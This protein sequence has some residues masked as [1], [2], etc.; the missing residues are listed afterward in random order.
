MKQNELNIRDIFAELKHRLVWIILATVVFGFGAYVYS[1]VTS[2]QTY[3][4]QITLFVTNTTRTSDSHEISSAEITTSAKLVDSYIAVLKSRKVMDQV[5]DHLPANIPVSGSQILSMVK[6]SAN[7]ETEKFTVS[8]TTSNSA[9]ATA[10]ANKIGEVAPAA[11]REITRAGD[12]TVIDSAQEATPNAIDNVTPTIL[13]AVA[14]LGL[15]CL[16]IIIIFSFN[17]TIW[18]ET[19]L[20]KHYDIPVFGSIP[21]LQGNGIANSRKRG[22]TQKK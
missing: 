1:A 8:V 21:R 14:G 19:D 6:A 22:G 20:E 11:I 2:V 7:N 4:A 16:I 12:A 15:S 3:T 9:Y 5:A 17:T 13:G 10:I 18:D